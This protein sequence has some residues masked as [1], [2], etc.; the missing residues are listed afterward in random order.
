[1]TNSEHDMLPILLSPVPT[2]LETA[3]AG[4]EQSLPPLMTAKIT[5]AKNEFYVCNPHE[6]IRQ[7]LMLARAAKETAVLTTVVDMRPSTVEI[8]PS[9]IISV[10]YMPVP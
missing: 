9:Y 1:V 2:G 3:W 5:T 8:N 10:E 7:Q 4:R 6:Y